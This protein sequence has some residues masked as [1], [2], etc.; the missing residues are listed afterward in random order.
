MNINGQNLCI[1]CMRP[2]NLSEGCPFCGLK[3]E[4]YNPIPRCLK[5]GTELA[6]RYVTGKVLGEGSFGITYM[7]WDKELLI[8]VAVKEYFPRDMVS[9][10]VICGSGNSVYLYE[11][12]KKNSYKDYLKKFWQEAKC[13]SQFNQVAGVV[14]VLDFFYENNTAYIVMQYID[15][16]SVKKYVSEHGV[17]PADCVL[18]SIRPVLLALE[19]VHN[20]GIVHRDISPDNLMI[21]K[22]GSLVLIDFGAA[23]MR[24][25][26]DTK[27][28]TVMF[29]RGFSPEEQYRYRGRWGAYTD[30]YSI[31]ATIY[32]MMT[33]KTPL[34]SVI[35]TF[36]DG[37]TSLVSMKKLDIPVRQRRAI[38]KGLAL[39]AKDRWQNIGELYEA[40]YHE[41]KGERIICRR[42]YRKAAAVI[43]LVVLAGILAGGSYHWR[44]MAEAENERIAVQV[45][46]VSPEPEGAVTKAPEE[47][48]TEAPEGVLY[49]DMIRVEG[50]A[51]ASA[52]EKLRKYGNGIN[53]VWQ[54]HYSRK[55]KKGTII[56]QSIS[57][58]EKITGENVLLILV[59]SRGS[60][61]VAVPKLTGLSSAVAEKKL[62]KKGLKCKTR[63]VERDERTGTVVA[64]DIRT[65]KK[66]PKATVVTI[67]VSKGR[68]A[69]PKP[70]PAAT[71]APS[72]N[73]GEQGEKTGKTGKLGADEF[74]GI[75][76]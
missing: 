15:G 45:G 17:M 38:M 7:G 76:Q 29:K 58:G 1:G 39:H 56:S 68:T 31:C 49:P 53:I 6:G 3:P 32:F 44:T 71:K 8:P 43:G 40:L 33:G 5:P 18:E 16:I 41:E 13:L 51:K 46:Q 48:V 35:R 73:A 66:V 34:D 30:V 72:Q 67:T 70:A 69:A 12:E 59:V 54:Y 20:T 2:I 57:E 26:D 62:K 24:N 28:M 11:S 23:R 14:S 60:K 47:T 10:D 22:D 25:V 64:Q 65:G 75:I 63:R 21:K 36:G 52:E 37:M 4:E 61:Q 42:R 19:Q 74:A 50:L 9:R 55:V 27:T